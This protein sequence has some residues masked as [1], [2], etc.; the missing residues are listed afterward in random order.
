MYKFKDRIQNLSLAKKLNLLLA[1]LLIEMTIII[2]VFLIIYSAINN[3]INVLSEKYVNNFVE[4]YDI[5][6]SIERNVM[7]NHIELQKKTDLIEIQQKNFEKITTIDNL[8][9]KYETNISTIDE[10]LT[11]DEFKIEFKNYQNIISEIFTYIKKNQ[12]SIANILLLNKEYSSYE[13]MQTLLSQQKDFYKSNIERTNKEIFALKN[14]SIIIGIAISIVLL[15]TVFLLTYSIVNGFNKYLAQIKEFLKKLTQGSIP[16]TKIPKLNNDVGEIAE[17]ANCIADNLGNI[18]NYINQIGAGNYDLAFVNSTNS[19]LIEKSLENLRLNLQKA[20]ETDI[21]RKIEDQRKNWANIGL[22]KFAEILR[23]SSDNIQVLGDEIIKNI[24][25]Y[26]NAKIGGLFI[27]N[28]TEET[29]Y[30]ELL[31]AFAYDRKKYYTKRINIGDGLVGTAALEKTTIYIT[32]VP[33]NYIE[34]ES[35]LGEAAPSCILI[36]PLKAEAG[37]L[38]VV[39]IAAFRT[40]EEYEIRFVEELA[41]S[42]AATFASVKINAR[43]AMLLEESQKQSE[44]LAKREQ[45]LT[46][47]MKEM[48]I[49]QEE[50]RRR[51]AEMTSILTGVDQTLL[52]I[53]TNTESRIISVNQRFLR[54]LGYTEEEILNKR[55]ETIF[56]E[57]RKTEFKEIWRTI[58]EGQSYRETEKLS[59]KEGKDV[60]LLSQYTPIF[61]ATGK[62]IRVLYLANDISEQKLTEQRNAKLLDETVKAQQKM[63]EN[64]IEMQGIITAVDQTLMKAEYSAE[65]SLL[66]ANNK[67]IETL[68]YDFNERKGKNI[69]TFI[70][71]EEKESFKKLWKSVCDGNL[72]QIPVKR[73][74]AKT[75]KDLWLLNQYTPIRD[76][77][78]NTLKVLYM[79]IDISEQKEIEERNSKLLNESIE[80]QQKMLNNEIE[81]KSIIST[82]DQTLMKA[83]YSVEGNLLSANT[84][85]IETLGYDFEKRKGKNILTFIQDEEKEDFKKL[86]AKV[87]EG[88]FYQIPVKRKSVKTNKDLWL[89]NQYTPIKDAK[90]NVLRILYMAIDITEQKEIEERNEKLLNESIANQQKM[91]QNETEL[92]GII[93]AI[94]QTLM[95]A[96]YSVNGNLLSANTKHIETLGYDFNERKGKNILTF[97]QDAEKENFKKIWDNVTQGN[98]YQITVKR[99]NAITHKDIWLLN[100]YTPI[101]DANNKV[102]KILYFAIDITEQKEAEEKNAKLLQDFLENQHKMSENEIEMQGIIT[103]VD[104]TL[105]KAEFTVEGNLISA[106]QKHRD[107][108]GYNYEKTIG[109]N[110]LYFIENEQ[111][112]EFLKTWQNICKGNLYQIAVKRKNK[113]TGNDIWLLNQYTPIKD[114]FGYV[115]KILYLAIDI[116]E[117][118]QQEEILKQSE[119]KLSENILELTKKQ[120]DLENKLKNYDI[121]NKDFNAETDNELDKKYNNWIKKFLY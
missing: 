49:T 82:I 38:G 109:K 92:K 35:G 21:Q 111:K 43:T 31:S 39:E 20:K 70:Q 106:N 25:Y 69:L 81:L 44:E 71:D 2:V 58:L 11:L 95:K 28:E 61:N 36:V 56:M 17:N 64:E 18:E 7:V 9:K 53:E 86:W 59:S 66:S 4:L 85:H 15:I 65:G 32:E 108:L 33:K 12:D 46:S 80:N 117:H 67:H 57:D 120:I 114:K 13:K 115:K 6:V 91:I 93:S 27:Y 104:Q 121:E 62:V 16:K 119:N 100:Q 26:L 8:I 14:R 78:G 19:N 52:K 77:S 89:L 37:M 3:K 79:A 75:G 99:K 94:D 23:R 98:A 88:I 5:T 68:G 47:T 96:E 45:E 84:K 90:G 42:I 105:L 73:K 74:S 54:T 30:L 51:A 116:T 103:A 24:I 63:L 55:I 110:I 29:A 41:D 50:S 118:K 112:E 40:F 60:W 83:E 107:I 101:I 72:H 48:E 34:I 1:I 22:T 10:S 87:R 102:L 76:A 113:S 97:V